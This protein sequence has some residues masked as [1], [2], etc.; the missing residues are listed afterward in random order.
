MG[1][2]AACWWTDEESIEV[3][4]SKGVEEVGDDR[5]EDKSNSQWMTGAIP[6]ILKHRR[7]FR[8]D[9]RKSPWRGKGFKGWERDGL[10][11]L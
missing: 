9:G 5:D 10:C 7:R 1:L 11:A 6:D 2:A 3:K 4:Q 8:F